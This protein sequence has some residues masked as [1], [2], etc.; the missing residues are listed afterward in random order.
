MRPSMRRAG[1]LCLSDFDFWLFDSKAVVRFDFDNE[2]TTLGVYVTEDPT[3]VLAAC[4]ARDKAW[5]HAVRTAHFQRGVRSAVGA[6]ISRRPGKPSVRG[7]QRGRT[8]WVSSRPNSR[9]CALAMT[10]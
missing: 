9:P 7:S 6:R 10:A 8:A 2:D 4:R 1:E 3:E 5:Y